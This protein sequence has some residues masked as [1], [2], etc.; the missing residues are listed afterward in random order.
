M[1]LNAKPPCKESNYAPSYPT[2]PVF[3]SGAISSEENL[4]SFWIMTSNIIFLSSTNKNI[5][6]FL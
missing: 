3:V 6:M 1:V 4:T 2:N 5:F